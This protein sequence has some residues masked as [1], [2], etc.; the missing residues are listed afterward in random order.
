ML[1][2]CINMHACKSGCVTY[3]CAADAS[4]LHSCMLASKAV[5]LTDQVQST[6]CLLLL[7]VHCLRQ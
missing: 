3:V 1:P 4:I 6:T 5:F 2:M 7:Q